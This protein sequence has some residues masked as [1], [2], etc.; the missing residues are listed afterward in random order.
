MQ[1]GPPAGRSCLTRRVS[2]AHGRAMNVRTLGR[3][4]QAWILLITSLILFSIF[5]TFIDGMNL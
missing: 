3:A 5:L 2:I 4:Q 1:A